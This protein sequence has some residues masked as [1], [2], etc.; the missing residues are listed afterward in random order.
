MLFPKV[1]FV[2]L[3]KKKVWLSSWLISLFPG[4]FE[5]MVLKPNNS[6]CVSMRPPRTWLVLPQLFIKTQY[7]QGSTELCFEGYKNKALCLFLMPTAISVLQFSCWMLFLALLSL[8]LS[9]YDS[10]KDDG[11]CLAEN[12]IPT[13]PRSQMTR[14]CRRLCIGVERGLCALIKM[15]P[16]T[17]LV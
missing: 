4:V 12:L 7:L 14:K 16:P 11:G 9:I 3:K 13:L 5:N 1:P 8:Q 6:V 17:F 2:E 15:H 10:Q